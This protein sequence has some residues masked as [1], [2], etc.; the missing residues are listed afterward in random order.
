[1]CG[2]DPT[3]RSCIV[4]QSG[5]TSWA[6]LLTTSTA[7]VQHVAWT[8]PSLPNSI[9]L[10]GGGG[11]AE[12][13]AEIVPGGGTFELLHG[14]RSACAIPDEET[15]VMTGGRYHGYVTRY[16]VN[17]FVEELPQLPEKRSWHTCASL[18]STKAFIVA[19][20]H[21]RTKYLS[22]VLTL[23]PGAS[24]WTPLAS[25]PRPLTT[26]V[27][28]IVGGKIRV[29][30]G[31]VTSHSSA[32]SEVLEY[33]P[34]P[35]N[36]W[37]TV[38]Q[39]ETGRWYHA[40]LSIGSEALPCLKDDLGAVAMLVRK[41]SENAED[42]FDKDFKK[43]QDGFA[44]NGESWI[45]LDKLH[46]LTSERSYSLKITMTDYDK[47]T[48]IAVFNN[49]KV[50][51]GEDYVL[52]VGSFNET[53]STLG[54]SMA[55]HSGMKFSTKDRDQEGRGCPKEFTSWWYN[56]CHAAHPTGLSSATKKWGP[57]YIAYTRGGERGNGWYSW[58]EAEYLL[59][60]N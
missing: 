43:Y 28:S 4:W 41:Q 55:Y 48:Y 40:V 22:S 54:D 21:D 45:G 31:Q 50:G 46:R 38:G 14:G 59:V 16:N 15:I 36:Q 27:T 18:P 33:Q 3:P 24:S 2:G 13:T 30:G 47:K 7:R 53:L 26:A 32:R 60:P 9:V 19:G 49:F 52:T 25:L 23:L 12:L 39:L 57:K 56:N 5:S 58:L 34:E 6:D 44:A 10:L 11:A 51:P 42:F 8:P 29:T 1:V 35:S 37:T 20:G 17:G